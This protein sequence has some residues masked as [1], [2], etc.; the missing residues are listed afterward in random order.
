MK[1]KR[2]PVFGSVKCLY[3]IIFKHKQNYSTSRKERNHHVIN[4][5]LFHHFSRKCQSCC[6]CGAY[7]YCSCPF[8]DHL[9]CHQVHQ[10][11]A[12]C[13]TRWIVHHK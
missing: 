6:H 9:R 2:S 3:L 7:C 10:D 5:T 1:A 8:C 11:K 13:W 12:F 4:F